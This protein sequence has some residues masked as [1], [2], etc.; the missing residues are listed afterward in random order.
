MKYNVHSINGL[1]R[2]IKSRQSNYGSIHSKSAIAVT[3]REIS[4][5]MKEASKSQDTIE[6]MNVHNTIRTMMDERRG[7]LEILTYLNE[8]YPNSPVKQFFGQYIEDY[9]RKITV[10]SKEEEVR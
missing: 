6:R 9:A 1:T 7:K 4:N 10:K 3:N 8:K 5:R 2:L